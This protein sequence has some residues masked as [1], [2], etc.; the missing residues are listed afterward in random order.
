MP[1][2]PLARA[3]ASAQT[4]PTVSRRA[5]DLNGRR[6]SVI[7]LHGSRGIEINPRAYE[8]Y[9]N[10]LSLSGIDVYVLR[11]MSQADTAALNPQ[12]T[13]LATREA[14]DVGRF[15]G[16]ADTVSATV[17]TILNRATIVPVDLAF[18]AS[19]WAAS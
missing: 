19:R 18:T 16:W 9:A 12:T 11:Y 6:P 14:Y 4:V 10:A 3:G 5:A 13:T 17:G 2:S 1:L 15:D 8:R 7:L